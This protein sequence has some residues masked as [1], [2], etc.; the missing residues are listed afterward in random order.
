L[1]S[2]PVSVQFFSRPQAPVAINV[3]RRNDLLL[4][5]R[6]KFFP[7]QSASLLRVEAFRDIASSHPAAA[8]QSHRDGMCN[9]SIRI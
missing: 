7:V 2:A 6:A 8:A 5:I 9:A 4:Q 3:T 1:P